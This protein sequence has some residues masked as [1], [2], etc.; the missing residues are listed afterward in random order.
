MTLLYTLHCI[1]LHCTFPQLGAFTH[2][3]AAVRRRAID[4][5]LDAARW[6]VE[7]GAAEVVVWS[8]FDGYDYSHQ[9]DYGEAWQ[10]IVDAF[11]EVSGG[12][13]ERRAVSGERG[14]GSGERRAASGER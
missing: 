13:G 11:R 4:L 1:V 7:L 3:D 5:T 12:A 10:Q 8:A 2:P 9:L 6:A 14:A